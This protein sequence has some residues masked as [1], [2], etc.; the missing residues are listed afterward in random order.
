MGEQYTFPNKSDSARTNGDNTE[1]AKPKPPV[2]EQPKTSARVVE[3]G[4]FNQFVHDIVDLDD[5]PGKIKR[6]KKEQV[7]PFVNDGLNK[8]LKYLVDIF[9]G[10]E[11]DA[12]PT[13]P[14]RGGTISW[15]PFTKPQ[16]AQMAQSNQKDIQTTQ[17]VY[18][19]EIEYDSLGEAE[20]VLLRMRE[21]L[22]RYPAGVPVALMFQESGIS[23]TNYT[24]ETFGWVDP[25]D[26]VEPRAKAERKINGKYRIRLPKPKPI[27]TR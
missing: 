12:K 13:N 9:T 4:P 7:V 15:S 1:P 5:I 10:R 24:M 2:N 21:Y 23:N 27:K 20:V 8:G 26:L 6:F 22:E 25:L 17:S 14:S 19:N 3:R 18:F 11:S 16:Q